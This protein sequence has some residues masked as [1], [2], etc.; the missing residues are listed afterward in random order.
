MPCCASANSRNSNR[1]TPIPCRRWST[2]PPAEYTP[3][4]T[5]RVPRPARLASNDPNVQNIPVRTPLG[6]EIR[7]AFSTM[8]DSGWQLLSADY[9]QIELRILAHMSRE[10]GLLD[11]FRNGEDI[12]NATAQAMYGVNEASSDQRRIAKILNFGVI[13][14]LG[15]KASPDRPTCLCNKV[16]SSSTSTSESTPASETSSSIRN[17][18]LKCAAT[19]K[20]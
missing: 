10:P 15:R 9:S 11:S 17:R 18:P 13:Y 1:P 5:K 19:P 4:S 20:R 2:R 16:E 14:G 6:R 12:H 7:N 3:P 8:Y